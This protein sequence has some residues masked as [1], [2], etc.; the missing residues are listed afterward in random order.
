MS[1]R[2]KKKHER[3]SKNNGERTLHNISDKL[4]A[5]FGS[6]FDVQNL[7]QMKKNYMTFQ[8]TNALRSQLEQG[9]IDHGI[10]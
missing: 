5:E 2:E 6:G 8:N 4:S 10:E 7:Q 1:Y 3:N 9:K